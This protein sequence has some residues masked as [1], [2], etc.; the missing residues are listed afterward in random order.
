MVFRVALKPTSSI[1]KK[2]QTVDIHGNPQEMQ[3]V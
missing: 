3:V 2:Q 1:L